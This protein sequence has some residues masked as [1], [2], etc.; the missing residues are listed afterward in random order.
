MPEAGQPAAGVAVLLAHQHDQ[1]ALTVATD[2]DHL[3]RAVNFWRQARRAG[4]FRVLTDKRQLQEL[5]M[6]HY[7]VPGTMAEY[8]KVS[9]PTGPTSLHHELIP[10]AGGALCLTARQI[11]PY[12]IAAVWR[13]R[14]RSG[15]T[16]RRDRQPAAATA[17]DQGFARLLGVLRS[18]RADLPGPRVPGLVRPCIVPPP[19]AGSSS[20][21]RCS[22]RGRRC[23]C[24]TG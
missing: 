18:A 14:T 10:T 9:A 2:A 17:Q 16:S 11:I 4:L 5:L 24:C 8:R 22:R 15:D 23:R 7:P 20:P 19:S 3:V 13:T 21:T 1:Q 12:R 6:R